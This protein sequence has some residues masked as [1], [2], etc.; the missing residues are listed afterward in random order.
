MRW[1]SQVSYA[2]VASHVVY[3]RFDF[4]IIF[5]NCLS[6]LL[7]STL[8]CSG[9]VWLFARLVYCLCPLAILCCPTPPPPLSHSLS[10]FPS[11]AVSLPFVVVIYVVRFL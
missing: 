2:F 3:L 7:S 9:L 10:M 4:N 1:A 8:F 5:S 6:G 11:I